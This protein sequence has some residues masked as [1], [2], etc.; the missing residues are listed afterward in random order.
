M[1]GTTVLRDKGITYLD[2]ACMGLPAPEVLQDVKTMLA[3]IEDFSYSD[4]ANRFLELHEYYPR[5][6]ENIAS[7]FGVSSEQIALVESTTQ[8]LGLIANSLPLKKGDNVLA[9]DL[10]FFPTILCWGKKQKES[11]IEV[12]Q[13]PTTGGEVNVSDFESKID[14]NTKAI[15]I[16]AVQEANGFRANLKELS[17]L[18]RFNNIYLI[19]DGIQEAGVL[20]VDLA[21]LDVDVYCAG[22]VKWLCNPFGTGFLYV[23][24]R[25]MEQLEPDFFGYFNSLEP[26]GG[27]DNYLGSPLRTPFDE[28]QLTAAAQKFETGGTGNCLGALGLYSAV[29]KILD[30]GIEV[31]ED[32]VKSLNDYLIKGLTGMGLALSGSGNP[33]NRAGFTTFSIPGG[34]PRE[35]ELNKWLTAKSIY[36]TLRYTSGI[37]GVRVSP[38]YYNSYEDIDRLL[39][40]VS[41]FLK[42]KHVRSQD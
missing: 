1:T 6:R 21:K 11:G 31:I 13:V 25:I 39:A 17:K 29:R 2:T 27:W 23:N 37:G 36:T 22:G 5:A 8:G 42:C 16:S 19:V 34:M 28:I 30:V 18:A 40:E 32:K 3:K 10:E 20:K 35:R 7:L 26:D 15:A 41:N 14:N 38:H 24:N 9:C 12:R 33:L 4:P